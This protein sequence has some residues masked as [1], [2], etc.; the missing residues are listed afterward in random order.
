MLCT[1]DIGRTLRPK[2]SLLHS[3]VSGKITLVQRNFREGKKPNCKSM[4]IQD[5]WPVVGCQLP[6]SGI[7]DLGAPDLLTTGHWLHP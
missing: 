1:L 3:M 4:K 7:I 5:Q 2:L 6:V